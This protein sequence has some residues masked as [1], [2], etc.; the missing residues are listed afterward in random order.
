MKGE[1]IDLL[2]YYHKCLY[3]HQIETVS[4]DLQEG[5]GEFDTLII[6][7]ANVLKHQHT[8]DKTNFHL[9]LKLN[10]PVSQLLDSKTGGSSK[11]V[12]FV[13]ETHP[14]PKGAILGLLGQ[15]L[16]ES[17]K[18]SKMS[19]VDVSVE[20]IQICGNSTKIVSTPVSVMYISII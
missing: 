5:D 4:R 17:P 14:D 12:H 16:P 8:V 6:N 19:R 2:R 20:T 13:L 11:T 1:N 3:A 15:H 9:V 10:I 7:P 18:L